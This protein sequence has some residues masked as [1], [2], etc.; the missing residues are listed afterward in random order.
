[1]KLLGE[2]TLKINYHH[3]HPDISFGRGLRFTRRSGDT[4]LARE[5][6]KKWRARI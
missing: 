1:M 4:V 5:I 2:I 6:L 3:V